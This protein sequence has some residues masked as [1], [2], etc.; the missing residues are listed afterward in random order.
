MGGW[1]VH[2]EH[3]EDAEEHDGGESHTF[4]N[5]TDGECGGDD[6]EG[7]LVD[8]PDVV[9]GPVG[10]GA[11]VVADI[12]EEC[13]RQSPEEAASLG[14]AETVTAGPPE[15]GDDSGECEA[16]GEDTENVLFADESTVEESESGKRHEKDEGGTDHHPC[17]V[18]WAGFSDER[19]FGWG[20]PEIGFDVF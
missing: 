8:G 18:T 3:P 12:A 17:V 16:L 1:E 14:E 10:V 7:E 19:S 9:G 5:G 15:E 4:R 20:V 11:G 6:G 13:V 2:D